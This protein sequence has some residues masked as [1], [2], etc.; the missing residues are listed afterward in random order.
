MI[1]F[2]P[3]LDPLDKDNSIIRNLN[4]KTFCNVYRNEMKQTGA[5]DK[6][7]CSRLLCDET[8]KQPNYYLVILSSYRPIVNN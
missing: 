1:L 8:M 4:H 7:N 5:Q 2:I 3:F 6:M